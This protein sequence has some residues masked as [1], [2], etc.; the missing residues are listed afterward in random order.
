M[1]IAMN[2]QVE[3]LLAVT[4]PEVCV[5]VKLGVL[6]QRKIVDWRPEDEILRKI[7]IPEADEKL[8]NLELRN[9]YS[10]PHNVVM[11]KSRS[12]AW[13]IHVKKGNITL[14]LS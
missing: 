5:D 10:P 13:T 7:F 4:S 1:L 12:I 8:H 9:I 14:R 2:K 6:F 3:S 11:I